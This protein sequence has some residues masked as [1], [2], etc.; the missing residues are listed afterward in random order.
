MI[1]FD[2]KKIIQ[3]HHN[4]NCF[5]LHNCKALVWLKAEAN[6]K[7]NFSFPKGSNLASFL[8]VI[9]QMVKFIGEI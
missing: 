9:S 8:T 3:V 6:L 2:K 1:L 7:T 4:N 5:K